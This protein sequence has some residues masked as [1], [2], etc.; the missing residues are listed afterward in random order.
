[1]F[2]SRFSAS[3]QNVYVFELKEEIGPSSWRTVKAAMEMAKQQKAEYLLMDLNTYGG[4]L[5]FADSIRT[6]FLESDIKTI[7]YINNNAASAGTLISLACDYIFMNKGASIGAATVVDGK[8]EVL[9]EKY[10]SYMRSLMRSTAE[11][12]GRNPILAEAF[13]DPSVS[14]PEWKNNGKLLTMTTSE[15]IRAKIVNAEAQSIQDIYKQLNI[16]SP[17]EHKYQ[18]SWTDLLINFLVNPAVS[19]ILIFLIIGGIYAEMQSPGIGFALVVAILAALLFFAPLYLQGLAANWEITLFILGLILLMLEVFVIPG[20]G[21]VGILGIC[22]IVC[23]LTFSLV[24]N[25]W[26]DFKLAYPGL[27]FNSFMVVLLAMIASVVAIIIF[28][29]SLMKTPAFKRLVLHDEQKANEGYTS[30]VLKSDM[31]GKEGIAKTVLRPSGKIEIDGVWY[32][33]VALDGFID[34]GETIYVEKHEN[35]NLF[36]R[37]INEKPNFV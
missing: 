32:D 27:L 4:M 28:G 22:F 24:A 13:V 30:S 8:G 18:P 12:K 15:A 23:G 25:D 34:A 19:G 2:L 21:I 33:A 36:V 26:L 37:K 11:A 29:K 6:A 3:A 31:L 16:G 5:N 7:A 35:Y 10:Q 9:P 14:A 20:F 1:M 17:V